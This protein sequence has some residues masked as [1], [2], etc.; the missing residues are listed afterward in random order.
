MPLPAPVC[1]RH[2]AVH[3]QLGRA[4]V[5]AGRTRGRNTAAVARATASLVAAAVA[6][7]V[8]VVAVAAAAA[9]LVAAAAVAEAR[10]AARTAVAAPTARAARPAVAAPDGNSSSSYPANAEARCHLPRQKKGVPNTGT[11]PHGCC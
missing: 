2:P 1:P 5:A 11:A 4:H 8:A 9:R 10:R 6:H 7:L 3:R